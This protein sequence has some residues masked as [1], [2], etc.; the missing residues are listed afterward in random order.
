MP[1]LYTT[2]G[3]ARDLHTV[4]EALQIR[5]VV[6]FPP[7]ES[8]AVLQGYMQGYMRLTAVRQC[9]SGIRIDT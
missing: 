1:F 6:S 8:L 4:G 7:P 9:V 5:V 3:K 2:R